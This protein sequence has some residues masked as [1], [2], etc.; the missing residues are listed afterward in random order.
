MPPLWLRPDWPSRCSMRDGAH[1]EPCC[2]TSALTQ[3]CGLMKSMKRFPPRPAAC[4][5]AAPA[6]KAGKIL[7]S[8]DGSA[9]CAKRSMIVTSM[10]LTISSR[11][12]IAVLQKESSA[13]EGEE[14][15]KRCTPSS[16]A[17]Q[18]GAHVLGSTSRGNGLPSTLSL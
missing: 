17:R 10:Q 18:P 3:A 16:S 4:V 12:D 1:S 14:D 5:T 11:R 8:G 2:C 7:E 15:V 6:P 13:L 9:L